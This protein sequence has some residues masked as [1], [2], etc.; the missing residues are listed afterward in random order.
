MKKLKYVVF[1]LMLLFV[2][3][4]SHITLA[5]SYTDNSSLIFGSGFLFY[6]NLVYSSNNF[7]DL[8]FP[9][10]KVL[11][12]MPSWLNLQIDLAPKRKCRSKNRTNKDRLC[13]RSA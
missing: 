7:I 5:D 9:L 8:A 13:Q 11:Q 10:M 3:N 6:K 2:M 4:L 12:L 1:S